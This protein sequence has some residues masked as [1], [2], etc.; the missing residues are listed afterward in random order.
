MYLDVLKELLA[1][2]A[3]CEAGWNRMAALRIQLA[4]AVA[5]PAQDTAEI[6][7]FVSTGSK[8]SRLDVPAIAELRASIA[9]AQQELYDGRE[10][11]IYAAQ[12]VLQEADEALAELMTSPAVH[13]MQL[14]LAELE[15]Q[16]ADSQPERTRF[17]IIKPSARSLL[18]IKQDN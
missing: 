12:L 16:H 14:R 7:A 11:E 9:A 5:D 8:M 3:S 13:D 2:R 10:A 6:S 4:Q 18:A 15:R 1:T 17:L